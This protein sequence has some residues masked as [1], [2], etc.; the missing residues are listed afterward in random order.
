MKFFLSLLLLACSLGL[1]AQTTIE[2]KDIAN[3]IGDSVKVKGKIFGVRYLESA[4]NTPTF[5]NVGGAYPNPLLTVVI[6]GEV[7]NKLGYTPED[8][9]YSGGMAVVTGKVELYKDKPQIVINDPQQLQILY[10]EEVPAS[11]LP[12]QLKREYSMVDFQFDGEVLSF[13]EDGKPNRKQKYSK[14][15]LLEGYCYSRDGN[16][17][18]HNDFIIAS[19]FPGG[20]NTLITFLSQNLKYPAAAAKK[21]VEGTVYIEFITL[22]DGSVSEPRIFQ[23]VSKELDRE[24]IRV[25]K[26]MPKWSPYIIEGEQEDFRHILPIRFVL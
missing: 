7:R 22:K 3:H 16:K 12:Q 15:K 26:K 6:W 23:G 11:Q 10:D 14:G 24:A 13:Y 19:E 5:I 9:K 4:K 25:V 2:L 17:R 21:G 1:N 20:M 18:R 8:K